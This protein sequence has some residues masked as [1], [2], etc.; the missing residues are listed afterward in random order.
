[1][2]EQK[3]KKV[4][5]LIVDDDEG[6]RYLFKGY[7]DKEEYEIFEANNGK[8]AVQ[9]IQNNDINI[10]FL[11]IFLPD[12]N[13]IEL[14][15]AILSVK[16]HLIVVVITAFGD[17]DKAIIAMEAGAHDYIEKPFDAKQIQVLLEAH[18]GG[19]KRFK[20]QLFEEDLKKEAREGAEGETVTPNPISILVAEDE[21]ELRNL[22]SRVLTKSGYVV[23]NAENGREAVEELK[24]KFYDLVITDLN[25]PGIDGIGVLRAAKELNENTDV[26]I[27]T[28]FGSLE[29]AQ[30]A[31]RYGAYDYLTKPLPNI[32]D[33]VRLVRRVVEK[34]TIARRNVILSENLK[35]K[36]F[37]LGVLYEVSNAVSYTIDY[38]QLVNILF[39]FLHKL[40]PYDMAS[41]FLVGAKRHKLNMYFTRPVDDKLLYLERKKILALFS[42]LNNIVVSEKDVS[43]SMVMLKERNTVEDRTAPRVENLRSVFNIPLMVNQKAAGIL[44]VSSHKENAFSEADIQ[45]VK[46]V[47]LQMSDAIERIRSLIASEKSKMDSMVESMAEGVVMIDEKGDLVVI[48][49]AVRRLL[50]FGPQEKISLEGMEK[51]VGQFKGKRVDLKGMDQEIAY[52]LETKKEGEEPHILEVNQRIVRGENHHKLGTLTLLRDITEKKKFDNMKDEFVSTVSHELRTPLN[53]MKGMIS[54]IL[55]GV[56]GAVSPKLNEYLR[57]INTN[58]DRLTHIINNLLDISR[59]EAGS[60]LLRKSEVRITDLIRDCIETLK[61]QAASRGISLVEK[62]SEEIAPCKVDEGRVRQVLINLVGNAIKFTREG[63]CVTVGALLAKDHVLVSVSDTGIGISPDNQAH[64]FDRFFQ[65]RQDPGIKELGTGLGLAIA[66]EIVEMHGGKIQVASEMGKG[67]CFS[68]TLPHSG[69]SKAVS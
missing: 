63:G 45:L 13:G 16:K 23:K 50:G 1:M 58:I 69:P 32:K 64:I 44:H 56:S 35:R 53:S 68:F 59:L 25:M 33:L 48:N 26:V 46:T 19:L 55:A 3:K 66:K 52:E 9:C 34:Q 47:T 51:R 5:V 67:S 60:V 54:N 11:D 41:S 6:F 17:I 31:L 27:L 10:C 42:S 49:P 43:L 21:E 14:L 22:L 30:D 40:I 12:R 65:A 28:G 29:T 7:V 15:K 57:R 18:V 61:E 4:G 8:E 36:V 20:E 38:Q 24:A 39:G 62:L 2:A 37:E